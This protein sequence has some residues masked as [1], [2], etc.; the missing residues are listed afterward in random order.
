MSEE[1]NRRVV[2]KINFFFSLLPCKF[3]GLW[4]RMN[5]YS[6]KTPLGDWLQAGK[7]GMTELVENQTLPSVNLEKNQLPGSEWN[8]N[9]RCQQDFSWW[10][11]FIIYVFLLFDSTSSFNPAA[12]SLD[13]MLVASLYGQATSGV[14]ICNYF[15]ESV[16]VTVTFGI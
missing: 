4:V 6:P 11:C 1:R 16:Q 5:C 2:L 14:W 15:S 8:V 9:V 13:Q 3:G 12:P 7:K 10:K